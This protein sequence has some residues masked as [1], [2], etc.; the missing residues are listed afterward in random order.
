MSGSSKSKTCAVQMA[1]VAG[2]VALGEPGDFD[3]KFDVRLCF[4]ETVRGC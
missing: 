1:V 3:P 4:Q 2:A